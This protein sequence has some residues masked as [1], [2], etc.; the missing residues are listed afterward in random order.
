[1]FQ[2]TL[3]RVEFRGYE[4]KD[5]HT[6]SADPQYLVLRVSVLLGCKKCK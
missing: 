2:T 6:P 1:M 3:V 4:I 5:P